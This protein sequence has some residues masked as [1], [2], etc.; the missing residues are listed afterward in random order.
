[1]D[2][3]K[4]DKEDK[5]PLNN[6]LNDLGGWPVLEGDSWNENSFNWIDT[7]IQLRRKGYSHDIFLKFVISPDHRN[8]S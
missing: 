8:T 1:M 6:T 3:Q 5:G 7:L 4:L 2:I